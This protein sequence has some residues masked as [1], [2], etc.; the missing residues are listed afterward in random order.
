MVTE[1]GRAGS[2][3]T[4]AVDYRLAPEHPYPAALEER[5][6][7]WDFLL[8][9]G[10]DAEH[11]AVGGDSAGGGLTLALLQRLRDKRQFNDNS[12]TSSVSLGHGGRLTSTPAGG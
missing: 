3:R 2:V 11:I 4:L 8:G 6:K 12:A 5:S 9:Q 1:A 7:A 10:F